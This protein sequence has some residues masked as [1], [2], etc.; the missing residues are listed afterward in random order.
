MKRNNWKEQLEEEYLHEKECYNV[1]ELIAMK[2]ENKMHTK[3]KFEDLDQDQI[4]FGIILKV[5]STKKNYLFEVLLNEKSRILTKVTYECIKKG[6]ERCKQDSREDDNITESNQNIQET[7]IDFT[8]DKLME[9]IQAHEANIEIRLSE[10]INNE[11]V[12]NVNV[13]S[14]ESDGDDDNNKNMED[15][16]DHLD[17]EQEEDIDESSICVDNED[18]SRETKEI[19]PERTC[20]IEEYISDDNLR[21]LTWD[22]NGNIKEMQVTCIT[23]NQE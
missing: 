10:S 22:L 19:L 14:D 11:V 8:E 3:S 4:L 6:I 20:L 1:A 18:E 7:N 2:E 13:Q 23:I 15:V 16:K 21:N 17:M 12:S 9:E 5:P